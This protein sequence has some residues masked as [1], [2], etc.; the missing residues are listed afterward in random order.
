MLWVVLT[1]VGKVVGVEFILLAAIVAGRR[2]LVPGA[3]GL[4]P[5]SRSRGGPCHE[6]H[7]SGAPL[8]KNKKIQL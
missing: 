6:A 2:S 7:G 5:W 3:L 1:L 8:A 4:S